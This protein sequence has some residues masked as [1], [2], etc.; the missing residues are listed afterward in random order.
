MRFTR[1][2]QAGVIELVRARRLVAILRYREAGDLDGALATLHAH[3]VE[4]AEVTIDTPGALEAVAEAARQG[5]PVG[6][7]TVV[8]VAQVEEAARAGARFVV[9]P[10]VVPEVVEAALERG[11]EPLPGAFTA[12]EV[13]L[14]RRHGATLVKLFP[15]GSLGPDYVRALRAPLSDVDLVATGGVRIADASAYLAAGACA[16]ALGSDLA[17]RQ[18]PAGDADHETLAERAAAA[19]AAVA[20][21]GKEVGS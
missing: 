16:V 11:L 21:A 2:V 5:R 9:S 3:G 20:G 10:G 1:A 6:V 15:A 12:S 4:L 14:A 18:P 7:G 13:L 17:G 8:T 19:V